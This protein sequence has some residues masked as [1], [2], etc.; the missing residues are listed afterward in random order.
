MRKT[1]YKP[2]ASLHRDSGKVWAEQTMTGRYR[3]E[4]VGTNSTWLGYEHMSVPFFY[5]NFSGTHRAIN[6]LVVDTFRGVYPSA[7]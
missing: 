3:Y 6:Q 1:A 2:H 4:H 7:H 5:A